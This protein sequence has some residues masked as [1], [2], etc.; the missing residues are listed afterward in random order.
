LLLFVVLIV[1]VPLA[2]FYLRESHALARATQE[3]GNRPA[4]ALGQSL[5]PGVSLVNGEFRMETTQ[6]F[7]LNADGRFSISNVDG[8]VEI[9]GWNSNQVTLKILIRGKSAEA[10][11]AVKINVDS[12]PERANV[13]TDFGDHIDWSWN[14][15]RTIGRDKAT[16]AYVVQVPVQAQ[17]MGVH[18]VDGRVLI[19]GVAGPITANT[20]DGAMEIKNAANDLKLSAVD[21]S[22]SVSMDSLGAGQ[23]VSLH[24]VD[25]AIK[26]AVP[27]DADADFSVHTVDGGV[28]SEFAEL[29][30]KTGDS[31][32]KLKGKLRNGSAQVTIE[33]VDGGV[34]IAKNR[35]VKAPSAKAATP[36]FYEWQGTHWL[37][38][39]N[40]DFST[41][42]APVSAAKKWLT[43][44]DAGNFSESWKETASFVQAKKTEAD[45]MNLLNTNRVPLG[46]L[47]SRQLVA[48]IPLTLTNGVPTSPAISDPITG[49]APD[50][51]DGPYVFIMFESS[52]AEKKDAKEK[53]T[54]SLEKDGQWRAVGYFVH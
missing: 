15:L 42:S 20:V 34:N 7:P 24:T 2:F 22:I 27:E 11:N 46:K 14:W 43:L 21:G 44:V 10:V 53:A 12:Q 19:D 35:V 39:T 25:G 32:N 16:V 5:P 8:P 3:Y 6:S 54:F 30:S 9:H 13:H 47:I 36:L 52:F 50:A 41:D 1:F 29:P 37:A 28:N 49:I 33:T 23:S 18:N 38:V 40:H 51:P 31:G 26:L 48:S 4:G 45:W 17:L